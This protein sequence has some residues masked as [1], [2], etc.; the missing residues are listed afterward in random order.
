MA[1]V[2]AGTDEL[3]DVFLDFE[4]ILVNLRFHEQISKGQRSRDLLDPAIIGAQRDGTVQWQFADWHT[5]QI[6]GGYW[7]ALDWDR[8]RSLE[9]CAKL[10]WLI[11]S[12]PRFQFTPSRE[13]TDLEELRIPLGD[14]T[15]R[16]L[17]IRAK[18]VRD[19]LRT[20]LSAGQRVVAVDDA[21]LD[22]S[23]TPDPTDPRERVLRIL[24]RRSSAQLPAPH[25]RTHR[26][27]RITRCACG[28]TA[29]PPAARA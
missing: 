16:A 25:R 14:E 26:H 4:R 3:D 8:L 1:G 21:Y 17:G 13:G 2:W 6:R 7:I 22:F 29:T 27:R 20:L 5:R 12:A 15:Y 23:V 24:R 10:M 28:P 9:G 11:F 19:R 18:R